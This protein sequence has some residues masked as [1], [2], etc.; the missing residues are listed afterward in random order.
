MAVPRGLIAQTPLGRIDSLRKITP[1]YPQ[2]IVR[3]PNFQ[4]G[5]YKHV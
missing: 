4:K 3:T 5:V 1:A 2:G